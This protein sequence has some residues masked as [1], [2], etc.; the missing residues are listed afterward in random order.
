MSLANSAKS[1]F[2]DHC[3]GAGCA[4]GRQAVGEI[5]LC[6]TCVAYSLLLLLFLPLFF[7]LNCLYLNSGVLLFVR[8]PPRP[9]EGGGRSGRVTVWS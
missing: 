5:V 9:T 2:C 4:I 8:S 1:E 6:I 3:L 7:L